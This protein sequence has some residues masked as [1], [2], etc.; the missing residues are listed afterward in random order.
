MFAYN[1][2]V[3]V[4]VWLTLDDVML[5]YSDMKIVQEEGITLFVSTAGPLRILYEI[6][7]INEPRRIAYN[8]YK[9]CTEEELYKKAFFNEKYAYD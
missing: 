1:C 8:K 6:D 5:Y 9:G 3:F 2:F 7:L 4:L